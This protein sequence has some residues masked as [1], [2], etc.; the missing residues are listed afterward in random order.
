MDLQAFTDFVK[1]NGKT[2]ADNAWVVDVSATYLSVSIAFAIIYLIGIVQAFRSYRQ[3]KKDGLFLTG[4]GLG[5]VS[6]VVA[7]FAAPFL[8]FPLAVGL[9]LSGVLTLRVTIAYTRSHFQK[10]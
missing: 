2:T 8:Y 6:Q 10:K 7:F 5:L 3:S 4:K 9:I 1:T